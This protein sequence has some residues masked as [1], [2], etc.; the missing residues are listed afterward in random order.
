MEG[1]R[2]FLCETIWDGYE[3]EVEGGCESGTLYRVRW[4]NWLAGNVWAGQNDATTPAMP[5]KTKSRNLKEYWP[6]YWPATS[7]HSF[8]CQSCRLLT[9]D[10]IQR[11]RN[12][13][14]VISSCISR[15]WSLLKGLQLH[16]QVREL[17]TRFFFESCQLRTDSNLDCN[18]FGFHKDYSNHQFLKT[19]G[20][21]KTNSP[22]GWLTRYCSQG[23][24]NNCFG[25][26]YAKNRVM[27]R[28]HQLD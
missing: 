18:F 15:F 21:T 2:V 7:I 23:I 12:R 26:L 24:G 27:L 5:Q 6:F 13:I 10:Q 25:C 20:I 16:S 19:V 14:L 11:N 17:L 22:T 9:H 28:S 4:E 1:W 3:D 8:I